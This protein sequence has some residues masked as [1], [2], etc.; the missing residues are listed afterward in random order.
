MNQQ[1]STPSIT[2]ARTSAPDQYGRFERWQWQAKGVGVGG[3]YSSLQD[4]ERAAKAAITK[5]RMEA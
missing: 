1:H 2:L 3:G 4:A 5:K